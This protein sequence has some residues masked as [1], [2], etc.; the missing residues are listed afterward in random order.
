MKDVVPC[1]FC[2]RPTPMF[3]TR[4]CDNCWEIHTR[5][6]ALKLDRPQSWRKVVDE[7]LATVDAR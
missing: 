3:G 1:M 2:E 4:L 5:L 6:V 7:I